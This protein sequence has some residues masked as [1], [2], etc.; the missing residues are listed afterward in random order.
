MINFTQIRLIK[1]FNWSSQ[2]N[3][4]ESKSRI[5][6][7]K[8]YTNKKR[9]FYTSTN[10]LITNEKKNYYSFVFKSNFLNQIQ[11]LIK[12][13]NLI[14][15]IYIFSFFFNYFEVFVMNIIITVEKIFDL[16]RFFLFLFVL[17]PFF[18]GKKFERQILNKFSILFVYS[19]LVM[20][21]EKNILLSGAEKTWILFNVINSIIINTS[22]W[23]GKNNIFS[24]YGSNE[25][26]FFWQFKTSLLSI[27]LMDVIIKLFYSKYLKFS[28]DE[29][30]NFPNFC[31]NS[32]IFLKE[33]ILVSTLTDSWLFHTIGCSFMIITYLFFLYFF[34]FVKINKNS[35]DI[36]LSTKN[37]ILEFL[38]NPTKKNKIFRF[39]SLLVSNF[40]YSDNLKSNTIEELLKSEKKDFRVNQREKN[41]RWKIKKNAIKTPFSEAL[42]N[43]ELPIMKQ[44]LWY[45]IKSK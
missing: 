25:N 12:K 17:I 4:I 43:G 21:T 10:P 34:A 7:L 24:L 38:F 29:T 2:P 9:K 11:F 3:L 20:V 26:R 40:N 1:A 16:L 37:F 23:I 41:N 28:F 13:I 18:S 44:N 19:N 32:Y 5:P 14:S 15:C 30:L 36:L 6:Y 42:W 31:L 8:K 35:K 39:P 45:E 22:A 27:F 33:I